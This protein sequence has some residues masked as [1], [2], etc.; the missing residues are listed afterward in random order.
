VSAL[1]IP[2]RR[3]PARDETGAEV[4]IDTP[5]SPIPADALTVE[6][7]GDSYLV[8]LPDPEPQ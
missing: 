7:D 1:R 8:T 4:T 6:C 5:A 2:V 3:V